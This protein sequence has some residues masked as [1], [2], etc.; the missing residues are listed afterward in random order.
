MLLSVLA[1]SHPRDALGANSPSSA[2]RKF[3]WAELS[4]LRWFNPFFPQGFCAFLSLS[5][6]AFTRGNPKA[7]GA[8]KSLAFS[9]AFV[10]DAVDQFN[11]AH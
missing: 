11:L 1:S 2:G 5:G 10:R 9:Q 7:S 6:D 8:S 4:L 3:I